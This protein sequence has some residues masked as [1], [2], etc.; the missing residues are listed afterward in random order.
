MAI[1]PLEKAERQRLRRSF[2]QM[3]ADGLL[4]ATDDE[5]NE[6]AIR[7]AADIT[8]KRDG[9][10]CGYGGCSRPSKTVGK[11]DEGSPD[12]PG[13]C[14]YHQPKPKGYYQDYYSVE[15]RRARALGRGVEGPAKVERLARRLMNKHGLADWAFLFNR[16][17]VF[18]GQCNKALR[19]IY[20]SVHFAEQH[21]KY[22]VEIRD[23]I[24]HEIAHALTDGRSHGKEWQAKATE[25]GATPQRCSKA[26]VKMP[27]P[28]YE[29]YR[30]VCP[31]CGKEHFADKRYTRY[32]CTPCFDKD[33][34][35]GHL[36]FVE[37]RG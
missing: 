18:F 1:S 3:R 5:I 16:S 30:A 24:L 29:R 35:R 34:S 36:V 22:L 26:H 6:T 20:L 14:G 21:D 11:I 37:N 31:D 33:R 17:T 32:V 10:I 7:Q 15:A 8:A 28:D 19:I 13:R 12:Y 25:L 9:R 2:R 4:V 23:T 27:E